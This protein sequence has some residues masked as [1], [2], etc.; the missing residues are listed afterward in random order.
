MKTK[1]EFL[2]HCIDEISGKRW[3]ERGTLRHS[4]QC[5]TTWKWGARTHGSALIGLTAFNPIAGILGYGLTCAYSAH[6]YRSLRLQ[7]EILEMKHQQQFEKAKKEAN[8]NNQIL[9]F[10]SSKVATNQKL[11][12]K[13]IQDVLQMRD[14]DERDKALLDY[15]NN[16]VDAYV[17]NT[18]SKDEREKFELEYMWL[19]VLFLPAEAPKEVKAVKQTSSK[20]FNTAV[21]SGLA[22]AGLGL[23]LRYGAK[24]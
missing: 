20:W 11:T 3:N 21:L 6:K 16:N 22:V 15:Y 5:D 19:K 8:D 4:N 12:D 23:Y 18:L 1:S 14:K 17:N 7:E 9:E 13:N 2:W 10:L 24:K